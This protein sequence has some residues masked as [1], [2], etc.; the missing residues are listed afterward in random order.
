MK[1]I[2]LL[3]VMAVVLAFS[4]AP[5]DALQIGSTMPKAS[6]KM[7]D[8]SGKEISLQDVAGK[9]G[10][11]V[12]FSCNTCPYVVKNQQRAHDVLSY[13]SSKNIGVAVL[14]S[15]EAYRDKDDSFDAMK[16]YGTQQKY[17]WY[18]AVDKNHV[19]ADAFGATRTPEVYLFDANNK[20]IYHG[21]IDDSPA[22]EAAVKRV[23]LK[24]AIDQM[25]NGKD[26]EVKTS[27]S[28]GCGIKR[29]G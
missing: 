23:H 12:M 17:N 13:A 21:A 5:I 14:N 2:N 18:Y 4:F 10:T 24:E 11:I 25:V 6:V 22:N 16:T 3:A 19:I 20:L 8:I 1:K 26:V 29:L 9:N 15:N 28:I 27:K 7:K